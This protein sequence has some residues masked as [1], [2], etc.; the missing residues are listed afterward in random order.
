MAKRHVLSHLETMGLKLRW[1][2]QC[3]RESKPAVMTQPTESEAMAEALHAGDFPNA[4]F[5]LQPH[6]SVRHWLALHIS[7]Y[8]GS[9][10][11]SGFP[12][13][14]CLSLPTAPFMS[15]VRHGECQNITALHHT[16]GLELTTAYLQTDQVTSHR[17]CMQQ[18][19]YG[20]IYGAHG[21]KQP[22]SDA[23]RSAGDIYS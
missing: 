2:Q 10:A 20:N 19:Q 23:L 21:R 4:F 17:C 9:N 5:A 22:A 13:R 1:R 16:P 14:M 11:A 8:S 3:R 7:E 6:P 12:S 15:V 18:S